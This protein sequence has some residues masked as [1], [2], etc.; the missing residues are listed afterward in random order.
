MR[1]LKILAASAAI[2]V[3]AASIASAQPAPSPVAPG[4]GPGMPSMNAAPNAMP[5]SPALKAAR[6]NMRMTCAADLA[7]FCPDAHPGPDHAVA[8]C[9]KQHR[10]EFSAPCH[11]AIMAVRQ[12]RQ[13]S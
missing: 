7:K 6:R 10:A 1:L 11:D 9:M 5:A 2:V 8:Q 12:A 4:A 3:A 13:A